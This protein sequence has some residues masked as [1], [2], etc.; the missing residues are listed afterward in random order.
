MRNVTNPIIIDQ[1]YCDSA[2][3]TTPSSC[4]EQV[5]ISIP[6]SLQLQYVG[7]SKFSLLLLRVVVRSSRVTLVRMHACTHTFH[8]Q[9]SAVAVRNISYRNIHGTSA[10]RVA[11]SLVCS[12]ALRC[13]GIRMQDVYLVGEGRYATCSYRN[14]TVVQSGYTFPFCS[15]EM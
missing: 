3:T 7:W 8:A 5:Y 10:S 2:R 4:H 13:D 11:I 1:N 15:A 12:A 9:G 14:A 6:S